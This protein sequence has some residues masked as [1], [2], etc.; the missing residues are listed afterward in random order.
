MLGISRRRR[1]IQPER[2]SEGGR[3]LRSSEAR[4][5]GAA[6]AEQRR[7]L[8]GRGDARLHVV[9][10]QP[11]QCPQLASR[12]VERAQRTETMAI[13]AEEIGEPVA[14]AR[15][16]LRADAFSMRVSR[17]GRRWRGP[18]LPRARLR[19]AGRRAARPAARSRP[20]ARRG[21][22]ASPAAR[23]PAIPRSLCAKPNREHPAFPID[24]AQLV[25]PARPI[26]P[27]EDHPLTSPIDDTCLGAEGPSLVLIRGRRSGLRLM[28]VEGPLGPLRAAG[29]TVALEEQANMAV[30]SGR[31]EH[32]AP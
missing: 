9:V 31:Q 7:E 29:L 25:R 18:A 24:D 19:A 6:A 22:R 2:E 21:H 28:P 32:P 4:E 17:R 10:A 27:D 20:A 16:R 1:E 12:P 30:P 14:I 11:H 13:G 3:S 26:D 15:V 23:A 5:A 8:V